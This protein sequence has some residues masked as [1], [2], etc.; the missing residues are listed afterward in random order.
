MRLAIISD[1]HANLEALRATLADISAAR[2]DRIVCLGDIVGYNASPGD[3]IALLR[4][5]GAHCVAGNHDRA[6]CGQIA[7]GDFNAVAARA[8]SWTRRHLAPEALSFLAGLPA[9]IAIEGHLVAVHGALHPETGCET[10]RLD[11]PERRLASLDALRGHPSGARICAFGHTHAVGIHE[12]R[13]GVA[14]SIAGD[15]AG[16]RDDAYYLV[17]PGSVGQPRSPDRRATYLVLDTADRTVTVARVAY[18]ASAARAKARKAGLLPPLPFLP[19]PVRGALRRVLRVM[20]LYEAVRDRWE[21]GIL[22]QA[23]DG[24]TA[25][26]PVISDAVRHDGRRGAGSRERRT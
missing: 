15:R 7:T 1:I 16:L 23:G 12:W 9:T 25:A 17:N 10:V 8:V 21:A 3:C 20:G 4:D 14:R 18:D 26:A 13:D 5:C 22:K 2:V 24:G 19:E 11:T 6:V